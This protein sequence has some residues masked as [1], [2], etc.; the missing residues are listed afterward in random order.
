MVGEYGGDHLDLRGGDFKGPVVAK[1]NFYQQAAAPTALDAL[2]ARAAGFTGRDDELGRLLDAFAPSAA[3]GGSV[4]VLVAAL[5]GLGGVGKTALAVEAAHRACAKGWFPGG[6]LFLDLHGYDDD[7]VTGE[8][9][10]EA[11][12]RAL[13]VEPEHIPVR[14]DER[15]ALF[16]SLLAERGRER[17]AVLVV[18]DNASSPDQVRPLL[19]GDVR[20]R[21]LV[22]SRSKLPQ[23]GAR[24][25]ALGEL[26]PQEAYELLDRAVRIADPADSRVADEAEAALRLARR[27]GQ[28]PL[29]LQIAAA[30][31]VLDGDRPVAELAAE[32]SESRDRLAHLDDGERSV[33]AA[34]DLS[35]RRLPAAQSRLLRLLALAPGAEVT[36]AAVTALTGEDVP[37]SRTLAALTRAH[38]VERG[39]RRGRWRL[40][41]LVRAFGAGVVAGDPELRKEGEAARERV[42]DFYVRWVTAADDRL[43]WLPG[44]AEPERFA[45]RAE[46]LAW[47]DGERAGL[48]AAVSWGR[49]ERFAGRAV[50]LAQCLRVYLDWRRHFDDLT[51][52]MRTVL[53]IAHRAGD[54]HHEAT[55][56]TSL[57]LA[58]REA[59]R[60][61][62]AIEA[63]TRARDLFRAE[64]DRLGEATAWNNLGLALRKADRVAEAIEAH[65]R[66]RD[67][68]RADGDRHG[69][70]TAWNNLGL[71]LEEAG[72][73]ADEIAAYGKALEIH[74]EF[75]DWHRAGVPLE[76]LAVAH[77]DA[78]L[79]ADAHAYWLQ[80]AD[81]YT[82]AQATN[83][84]AIARARAAAVDGTPQAAP[85]VTP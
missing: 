38:L 18:A 41:D 73:V 67:L 81:A 31:L 82:Q 35:Y 16:R 56:W 57:G 37:P 48:V 45:D 53:E 71:A 63:H 15:G 4:P 30:L 25:L 3:G 50:R 58:L 28:L 75:E 40:H 70:A 2:P 12:L 55:A 5:S 79:P 52:V 46:A 19:P 47:L 9:A 51:A 84:A 49:E 8:Q 72:R 76:N 59:G 36:E 20:H 33:R 13:G 44:T 10:L 29:A 62:E 65:T 66:A 6:V 43:R 17:G 85:P 69:E 64:G 68:F 14:A 26:A 1:G 42:L 24:L 21:L 80:A 39:S 34:F 27:C 23:L 78:R 74:R 22:T 60:V 83:E 32:L 77:E 54:R 7:P 61:A 11:L